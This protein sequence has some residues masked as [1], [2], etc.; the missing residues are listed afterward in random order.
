MSAEKPNANGSLKNASCQEFSRMIANQEWDKAMEFL[1][2]APEDAE[3]RAKSGNGDG[4]A[5]V[6]D[7]IRAIENRDWKTVNQL[8][9]MSPRKPNGSCGKSR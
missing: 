6:A 4:H 5:N 7:L 1:A 2:P 9:G 8:F 3:R